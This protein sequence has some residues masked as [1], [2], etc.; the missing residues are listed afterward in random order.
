M[1]RTVTSCAAVAIGTLALSSF[2]FAQ[3]PN[4]TCA[5]P[6]PLSGF[7]T[8]AFTTVGATTDGAPDAACLFFS[9]NQIYKDI[10]FCWTAPTS[11]PVSVA[12]CSNATW[13]TKIAVYHGCDCATMT[14]VAC[15]DDSCGTQSKVSFASDAGVTYM[16]RVGSY[17][18]PTSGGT[19]GSGNLV[20]SD[21][22][23]FSVVREET[24]HR[25]VAFQGATWAAC[26]AF[27]VQLG[28]HLITINDAA[29]NEWVRANVANYGGV[30]RRLWIGFNDVAVEGVFTWTDGTPVTFTNWNPG[31]PNNSGGL[32][33][34][35]ELLGSNGKWNDM[36][37]DG[38]LQQ[39]GVA[40][41][42]DTPPPPACPADLNG[43]TYIDGLD[44]TEI[45]SAW[46][47]N[48]ADINGDGTTDGLDL[49]A[50]LAGWGA[51]P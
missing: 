36:D 27:A 9:Q 32:E 11:G 37:A 30:D 35:T 26:E 18:T 17:G 39:I 33:D 24:G 12:T 7:G 14:M 20:I 8:F 6:N 4:D 21:G 40:E 29:E 16:I 44:L 10:W 50:V 15:S 19:S 46:G 42:I 2:A 25:Y 48:A 1:S 3:A 45:L 34:F 22:T 43:D 23:L 5:T 51:C 31:E 13:D 28:G 49:S 38:N 47:S 41:I